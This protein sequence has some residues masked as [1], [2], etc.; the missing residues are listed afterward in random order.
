VTPCS[1]CGQEI[2][3][4]D[5]A[6]QIGA[7]RCPACGALNDLRRSIPASRA[8]LV[9]APP[10]W[11]IDEVPG[12]LNVSWRWFKPSGLMMIPFTLFWNGILS[13]FAVATTEGFKHPERLLIGLAVPHVWVG[14]GLVWFCLATLFNSTRI[15][16]GSGALTVHHGPLWWPGN[17]KLEASEVTQLFVVGRDGRRGNST[18]E[19]C[20]VMRDGRKQVV[21]KGLESADEARFLEHSLERALRIQDRPVAGELKRG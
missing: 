8:E 20:A 10:R 17:R 16:A 15:R 19:V 4:N 6:R 9:P 13:V 3:E 12:A 21:L 18:Y 14:L 5:I 1:A 11:A 2:P 7:A